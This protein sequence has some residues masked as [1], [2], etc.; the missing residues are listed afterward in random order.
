MTPT[1]RRSTRNANSND[2]NDNHTKKAT[3]KPT[4]KATGKR[5]NEGDSPGPS[6]KRACGGW[7]KGFKN[8][9]SHEKN[10]LKEEVKSFGISLNPKGHWWDDYIMTLGNLAMKYVGLPENERYTVFYNLTKSH[11]KYSP[12]E[13]GYDFDKWKLLG[14][15]KSFKVSRGSLSAIYNPFSTFYQATYADNVKKLQPQAR[16]TGTTL[17]PVVAGA[18]TMVPWND[19]GANDACRVWESGTRFFGL[20]CSVQPHN[21]DPA[22]IWKE[23]VKTEVSKLQN[24]SA[25]EGIAQKWFENYCR[26]NIKKRLVDLIKQAKDVPDPKNTSRTIS[27]IGCLYDW[28]EQKL[29]IEDEFREC[30]VL[31]F[32]F[33]QKELPKFDPSSK[34]DWVLPRWSQLK[35]QDQN[36]P[37]DMSTDPA[38]LVSAFRQFAQGQRVRIAGFS[39]PREF[40]ERCGG[41]VTKR[42]ASILRGDFLSKAE[43]LKISK[44]VAFESGHDFTEFYAHD[45]ANIKEHTKE[46]FDKLVNRL[47]RFFVNKVKPLKTKFRARVLEEIR[48]ATP[49]SIEFRSLATL[50]QRKENRSLG[51]CATQLLGVSTMAQGYIPCT[52]KRTELGLRKRH[53]FLYGEGVRPYRWRL[54]YGVTMEEYDYEPSEIPEE[55]HDLVNGLCLARAYWELALELGKHAPKKMFGGLYEYLWAPNAP[56]ARAY[57]PFEDDDGEQQDPLPEFEKDLED[58]KAQ[59]QK[60]PQNRQDQKDVQRLTLRVKNCKSYRDNI[61]T[62]V[63]A[64]GGSSPRTIIAQF[65]RDYQEIAGDND[66]KARVNLRRHYNAGTAASRKEFRDLWKKLTAVIDA[67]RVSHE[68]REKLTRDL[69]AIH[70]E[71]DNLPPML[72]PNGSFEKPGNAWGRK[73]VETCLLITEVVLRVTSEF[74]LMAEWESLPRKKGHVVMEKKPAYAFVLQALDLHDPETMGCTF[75]HYVQSVLSYSTPQIVPLYM[76]HFVLFYNLAHILTDDSELIEAESFRGG[77]DDM[78]ETHDVVFEDTQ[79]AFEAARA[80]FTKGKWRKFMKLA[81]TVRDS[82]IDKDQLTSSLQLPT[83]SAAHGADNDSDSESTKTNSTARSDDGSTSDEDSRKRSDDGSGD[84]SRKQTEAAAH[85][86]TPPGTEKHKAELRGSSDDDDTVADGKP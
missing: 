11:T 20:Y 56:P 10:A 78:D 38:V 32:S 64:D 85:E 6:G 58:A 28:G 14:Y 3:G 73:A 62:T 66:Q 5:Q 2:S 24:K 50:E 18:K 77:I 69:D 71:T 57:L 74:L 76:S 13:Q 81:Q 75:D 26:K 45:E 68:L 25:W 42:E 27:G 53:K 16:L 36:N 44:K 63:T 23:F 60:D 7:T 12:S 35:I 1:T 65:Y 39:F 31:L 19:N 59:L 4:E 51:I 30:I 40:W 54:R 33:G 70:T 34:E 22:D 55:D 79:K 41:L 83:T 80:K 8:M 82:K 49:T 52:L 72:L 9:S 37:V 47:Y 29:D 46:Y 15:Q 61:S 17:P 48:G 86:V 67:I 43:G 21:K 84:D